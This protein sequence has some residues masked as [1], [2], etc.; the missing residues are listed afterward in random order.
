MWLIDTDTVELKE[1]RV[2]ESHPYAVL[3]H[4]WKDDQEVTFRSFMGS[5]GDY[6][7][8]MSKPGF[9]KIAKTCQLAKDR[10]IRY[11]WVDTCCIDK[12]SSAE[13]SE[14]INSM[15]QW[16]AQAEVCFVYLAD[17][18]TTDDDDF[19]SCRWF[20]RGW[21][22]QELIAPCAIEF[23]DASWAPRGTKASLTSLLS[24]ITRI[25]ADVLLNHR[26]L[27]SIPV[28]KRMSWAADR[29]TTRI[30]DRAYCL[31]GIFDVHLPLIYGEGAKSFIRLQE[32][33]IQEST[34]L[35]LFSWTSQSDEKYRGLFA[36]S[37]DEFKYC[38]K[39]KREISPLLAPASFSLTN[40]GPL[41]QSF[42]RQNTTRRTLNGLCAE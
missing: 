24:S 13:L 16:Y 41:C 29:G 28:A 36:L 40:K 1:V 37:P 21:T 23:Y 18:T 33:I 17:L 30:E 8:G 27:P 25:D 4:T 20:R 7:H 15:F 22:L 2:P 19:R 5:A 32:A 35:S 31:F 10:G 39:I 38:D 6:G 26:L 42:H 14:A 12:S 9:R 11:A 34:D 3:S